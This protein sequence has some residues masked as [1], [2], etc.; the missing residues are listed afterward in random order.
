MPDD[1]A[2]LQ[3]IGTYG[4]LSG[5][6]RLSYSTEPGDPMPFILTLTPQYVA[7]AISKTSPT[8]PDIQK[9]AEQNADQLKAIA[10]FEIARGF[11][12]HTLD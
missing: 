10:T 2:E 1:K 11:T 4:E 5:F 8:F 9:Y 7:R 12:R 3:L 6:L